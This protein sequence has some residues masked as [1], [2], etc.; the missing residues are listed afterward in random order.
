MIRMGGPRRNARALREDHDRMTIIN[1][2]G[3]PPSTCAAP[4][5]RHCGQSA[6]TA[7]AEIKTHDRQEKQLTLQHRSRITKLLIENDGLPRRLMLGG[8]DHL[9][10]GHGAADPVADAD[11]L[12][13]QT[14][15]PRPDVGIDNDTRCGSSK[16]GKPTTTM[17]AVMP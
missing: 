5:C 8:I 4:C 10:F 6:P 17:T 7:C 1:S 11:D 12:Q 15:P 13:Q 14:Q 3:N 16:S 9:T 2:G